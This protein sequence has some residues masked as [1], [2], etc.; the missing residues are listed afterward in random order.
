MP[1][2]IQS[3]IVENNAKLSAFIAEVTLPEKSFD[4]M[5]IDELKAEA[6]NKDIRGFGRMSKQQLIDKLK[7]K[8]DANT[9]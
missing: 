2:E 5:N 3:R 6:K 1:D 8:T 4:E 9:K 7:G